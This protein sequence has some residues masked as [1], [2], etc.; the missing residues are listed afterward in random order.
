MIADEPEPQ[1]LLRPGSSGPKRFSNDLTIILI[2]AGA[3]VACLKRKSVF[4]SLHLIDNDWANNRNLCIAQLT[5]VRWNKSCTWDSHRAAFHFSFCFHCQRDDGFNY[6]AFLLNDNDDHRVYSVPLWWPCSVYTSCYFFVNC[7]S[8][9]WP[10]YNVDEPH[11][12]NKKTFANLSSFFPFHSA[13]NNVNGELIRTLFMSET[14]IKSNPMRCSVHCVLRCREY[15]YSALRAAYIV[16]RSTCSHSCGSH[17]VLVV[18]RYW[19]DRAIYREPFL[20]PN[21]ILTC[22]LKGHQRPLMQL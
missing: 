6:G 5:Q 9:N 18:A 17:L 1:N 22:L 13:Q 7:W 10:L 11:C 15:T 21:T 8:V 14:Q 3:L 16:R 2:P 19:N 20:L 12:K 4:V